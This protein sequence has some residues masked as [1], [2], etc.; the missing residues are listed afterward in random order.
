MTPEPDAPRITIDFTELNDSGVTGTATLYEDGD[1]TI[2]ELDLDDTG[3]DHPAH[4]HEGTCDDLQP[5]SAYDLENVGEDG[6]KHIAGRCPAP[7][8]DRR[9]LRDRSSS[10]AQRARHADRVRRDRRHARGAEAP[11][12]DGGGH[13]RRLKRRPRNQRTET[14]TEAPATEEPAATECQLT[15]PPATEEPVTPSPD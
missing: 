1:Q 14:A 15:E 8:P 4:I 6:D 12:R 10:L 9:R 5:E 11:G 7:G 2:V 3:E 13:Q